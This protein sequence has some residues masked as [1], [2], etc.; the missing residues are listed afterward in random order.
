MRFV[1]KIHVLDVMDQV[2]VSGYV[3]DCDDTTDPDHQAVEFSYEV[4][5]Y[6][7][8]RHLDWLTSALARRWDI[9]V[10]DAERAV[11]MRLD[12]VD[13]LPDERI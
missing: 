4:P 11:G 12:E 1:A 10:R 2:I 9:V 8:D 6:G 5:S 7:R 3:V 13:D